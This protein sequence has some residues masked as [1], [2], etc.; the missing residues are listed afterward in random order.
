MKE[1][2]NVGY[3]L[4]VAG[5][6]D[7]DAAGKALPQINKVLAFPTTIILDKKGDVRK[8]HTGFSGPGTGKYY[9]EFVA[10]FNQ[11]IDQL[12]KE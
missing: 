4:A 8:I 11:T 9:E 6:A 12:V 1:R 5:I 7:K 2:L 10:D 3:D